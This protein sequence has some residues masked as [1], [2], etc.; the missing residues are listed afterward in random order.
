[1]YELSGSRC[2]PSGVGT[3]MKMAS[4]SLSRSKSV[5]AA[6]LLP[7]TAAA[8]RFEPM[9][10]MNDSPRESAATF[11]ASTSKPSTRNPVSWKTSARGSPTY[12]WPMTPT[13]ADRA[14]IRS[15]QASE[16]VLR[17]S[18]ATDQPFFVGPISTHGREPAHPARHRPGSASYAPI[19]ASFE[20]DAS[21][22]KRVVG[23]ASVAQEKPRRLAR[24]VQAPVAGVDAWA[25]LDQVRGG[26]FGNVLRLTERDGEVV[27]RSARQLADPLDGIRDLILDRGPIV[28]QAE[29]AVSEVVSR[30]AV[31]HR[32]HLADLAGGEPPRA[33]ALGGDVRLH[34]EL[35]M[36]AQVLLVGPVDQRRNEEED[37]RDADS[38]EPPS[39]LEIA[40]VAIVERE[41]HAV[42]SGPP[43]PG[44]EIVHIRRGCHREPGPAPSDDAP[45]P[46]QLFGR[47]FVEGDD[48][49]PGRL[50]VEQLPICDRTPRLAPELRCNPAL[51]PEHH[52]LEFPLAGRAGAS[53]SPGGVRNYTVGEATRQLRG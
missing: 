47:R 37:G 44:E 28:Q 48:A 29:I 21:E 41:E 11:P 5:V 38:G 50:V 9:C 1:M 18:V 35:L 16:P 19:R 27:A 24:H 33:G 3:Q 34:P 14:A 8:I 30:D 32:D 23:L 20:T 6:Y 17:S 53:S 51:R 15:F 42:R 40:L 46:F 52:P 13:T 7:A 25:V 12:P 26:L 22:G 4:H 39:D 2:A 45:Q 31:A 36:E 49:Q 10:W 43:P